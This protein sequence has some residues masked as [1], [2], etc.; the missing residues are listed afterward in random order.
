M[1]AQP[2]RTC[3]D[4]TACCT[5][6]G[7]KQIEKQPFHTC[8]HQ[9]RKGCTIYEER[10]GTC[11][12]YRCSWLDG[13][14]ARRDRPDRL[15]VIFDQAAPPNVREL[16]ELAAGGNADA[17]E[18]LRK[19]R[20]SIRVREVRPR[21]LHDRR[22]ARKLETLARAGFTV[23]LIPFGGRCLPVGKPL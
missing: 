13:M 14:G 22:V 21:A 16:E 18:E 5:V 7:V 10:P 11:A 17:A 8:A 20:G 1:I 4:C 23:R 9:G 2:E 19:A 6:L 12:A 3:G 15:G